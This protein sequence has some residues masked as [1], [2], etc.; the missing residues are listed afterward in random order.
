MSNRCASNRRVGRVPTMS[1]RQV[2]GVLV[3]VSRFQPHPSIV[4]ICIYALPCGDEDDE[5]VSAGDAS[6]ITSPPSQAALHCT[7]QAPRRLLQLRVRCFS[8]TLFMT[9]QHSLLNS[10]SHYALLTS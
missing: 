4:I 3:N 8:F 2:L 10:Y 1:A 6:T 9:S 7:R 5:R